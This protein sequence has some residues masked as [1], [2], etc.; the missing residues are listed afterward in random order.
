MAKELKKKI[1]K[2]SFIHKGCFKLQST[3]GQYAYKKTG[4][5]I[6]L[7]ILSSILPHLGGNYLNVVTEISQIC[8]VQDDTLNT[9]YQK[10]SLLSCR[11]KISGHHIPDGSLLT[12]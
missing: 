9:L 6:I 7:N 3:R 5:K 11:L 4:F 2:P 1:M 8:L 12:R 10:K